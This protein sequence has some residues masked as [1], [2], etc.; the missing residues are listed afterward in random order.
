[1]VPITVVTGKGSSSDLATGCAIKLF[2]LENVAFYVQGGVDRFCFLL[3]CCGSGFSKAYLITHL[4][5]RHI[6]CKGEALAITKHYL[7]IDLVVFER[8]KPLAPSCSEHEVDGLLHDQHDGFTLS[9]LDSL[10]SKRL[11]T[12]KSIPPKCRLG[13]SRVLKGALDKVIC[14]PDDISCWRVSS[15]P[16]DL[17]VYLVVV[18]QLVRETL[19]KSSS[20]MLDVDDEDLDLSERNLKQCSRK[21]CDGHYIAA[22]RV[23]FSS[24]IAPYNDATLQE[25]KTKHPFKS[26][27]SLPDTPNDHHHLIASQTLVL[28]RI[29]SFPRGISCRRDGLRAQHLMDYLSGAAVARCLVSKVSATMVGHSLD[30]YLDDLQFGVGV[31]GGGEA[32]L[33]AVNRLIEDRGD[34]V[35]LRCYCAC[36]KPLCLWMRLLR[37]MILNVSCCFFGPVRISKLYFAMCTCLPFV[38]ESAQRSFDVAFRSALERIV[39]ASG[40]GFDDWQWRLA[41][42]PYAFRGLGIYSIGDVLNYAF[43]ASRLLSAAL[44]TKLLQQ[45]G[46]VAY[47]STFDDA[48]SVFNTSIEIDF[49]TCSKFFAGDTYGDHVVSC[50]DIIGIKH[51][52]NVVRDTLVDIC[53]RSGISAGIEVDVG[54]GGGCDKALRPADILLYSWDR[55]LDVYVDLTG[56]SPLTRT[57]MADFVSGRAILSEYIASAPLTTLVKPGGGIHP[58]AVGTIW[59]RLISMVNIVMI[60]HLLDGYLNDLQFGVGVSGEGEAILYVVNRLFEDRGDN[61]DLS[62]LL[63]DFKNAFNLVY[64]RLYYGEHTLWSYQGVQQGDPLGPLLFALVLHPLICKIR[65]SFI[66]SFHAWYM[67]DGA[68]IGDTLVVGN[69][70][71]II[72]QDGPRRGLH[73]NVNKTKVFWPKED[74][75]S[76]VVGVF[77]PNISLPMY[78]VKLLCDTTSVDL[79]FSSEL[80]L[81]RVSRSIELIDVVT[82]LNDPRC[83]LLLLRACTGQPMN[84]KTYQCVLCY[85]LGFPLF[86]VPNHVQLAAGSLQGIFMRIMLYCAVIVG[87]KHWHNVMRDTLVDICF[88]SGILTCKEVDIGLSG[89]RDKPLHLADMLLYSGDGGLDVCVNLTGSSPS[90]QTGMVDFVPDHVVIKAAQRKRVKYEANG[91]ESSPWLKILVHVLLFIFFVESALLLLDEC[92]P[93]LVNIMNF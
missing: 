21:I 41:T 3:F 91:S 40:P 51:M 9:F 25:L 60:G 7:L 27:P 55:G 67:D 45:V 29:K 26:V 53:F 32:I 86:F 85:Q 20:H 28:E 17:R 70:L 1:M 6:H 23:L 65:D 61:V 72:M 54:F 77:P 24:G 5:D 84:G 66:L 38:F 50:A 69:V 73:L 81:R 79:D 74:P 18:L 49:L 2:T 8:A 62:M 92:G 78:V 68:I 35:G 16:S 43:L 75:R 59:R 22:V 56:S 37:S 89:G 11:R 34:D 93:V 87:T 30:G 83:E 63:V 58:I 88:R 33:H 12:V 46:I 76:R 71:E 80:A 44:Q 14:N 4:R 42:L 47:G 57:G 36:L 15:M 90:T 52:N 82:K 13:F 31:S 39:T 10:F 64:H 48:S 19:A